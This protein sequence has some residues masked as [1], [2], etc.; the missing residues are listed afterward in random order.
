[1][2]TTPQGEVP[3]R[4]SLKERLN[5]RTKPCPTCGAGKGQCCV[6]GTLEAV[7]YVH[8]ARLLLACRPALDESQRQ[9]GRKE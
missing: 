7:R 8:T 5:A 2:T 9:G 6:T 1:M 4:G 3:K